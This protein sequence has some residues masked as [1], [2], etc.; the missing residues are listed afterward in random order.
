MEKVSVW[1]DESG[2]DGQTK[3]LG[4]D[5]FM[6]LNTLALFEDKPKCGYARETK[7]AL[8]KQRRCSQDLVIPDSL[9]LNTIF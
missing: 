2:V 7:T 9:E 6:L 8:F 1:I 4:D 3:K 5:S